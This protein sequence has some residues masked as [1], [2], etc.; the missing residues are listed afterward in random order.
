MW[1]IGM[2]RNFCINLSRNS[3]QKNRLCAF[4]NASFDIIT[5]AGSL[6]YVDLALLLA[7][8]HRI[9]RPG[10]SFVCIDSFNHNPVY[11]LNRYIHYRMGR[12]SRSTLERMPNR[13]TLVTL[14]EHFPNLEVRYFG[15]GS[16]LMPA[17][18]LTMGAANAAQFNE[19][20]DRTLPFARIWAFKI[21][22]HGQRPSTLT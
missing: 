10:G 9:L 11:R 18:R 2:T 22:A 15:I 7:E 5:C 21:V 13:R 20:L 19:W 6:S 14:K 12:R 3:G 4:A 17:I 16:F 1:A 8:I